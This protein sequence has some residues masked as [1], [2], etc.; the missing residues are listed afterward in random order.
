[1]T[2]NSK[3]PETIDN[4]GSSMWTVHLGL[5]YCSMY[6]HFIHLILWS[7]Y[8]W[9][10]PGHSGRAIGW[11]PCITHYFTGLELNRWLVTFLSFGLHLLFF[12]VVWTHHLEHSFHFYPSIIMRLLFFVNV[13]FYC[14]HCYLYFG[15]LCNHLNL[16]SFLFCNAAHEKTLSSIKF[17]MIDIFIG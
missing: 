11:V 1:M 14:S 12:W 5:N 13:L 7:T 15:S 9:D 3:W 10:K 4:S 16:L 2:I 17:G 8:S 6:Q